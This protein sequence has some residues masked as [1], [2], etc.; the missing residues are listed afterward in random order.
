MKK[1]N[2]LL[3]SGKIPFKSTGTSMLPILY[4]DDIIYFKK[5]PF[6][7][8]K[9]NDIV[10]FKKNSQLITHRVIYKNKKHVITK[11]DNNPKSD[12]KIFP[13]QIIGKVYQIKRNDQIIKPETLYL[14]QS[15]H[16][17]EEI[18]KIK[19]EFDRQKINYVFLKGLPLH[20][21]FEGA[22][23]S[24]LYAD[25][26]VL[27]DKTDFAKA[28][29]ILFKYGYQKADTA[30]SFL[31]KK[32]K[33]K[34]S[35]NTY[36][37][38]INGFGVV[39]DI[40]LEVVFMMTQL[41]D[42]NP[43]YSQKLIDQMTKEFLQTRQKIKILGEQFWILNFDFLIVYL[44]LHLFHHNFTGAFR[45]QFLDTVVRKYQILKIKN[46]KYLSNIKNIINKYQINNFVY[47]AFYLL[48]KYYQTPLPPLFLKFIKPLH[49]Y[50]FTLLHLYTFTRLY[51]INIFNDEPRV[52]AGIK[53]FL[54][55]FFLSPNPL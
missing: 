43:L 13:K 55:L 21:Y 25:C 3:F 5:I 4:P 26:D 52:N 14:I 9:V 19:K 10:V 44:A 37:K 36:W 2:H 33:N 45:Y 23:P 39:F 46:Q 54:N 6:S 15:T 30:L 18:V 20:L 1:I 48:K 16:Y 42:L 7:K 38:N 51:K 32:L 11:G 22:H 53:R 35:E 17:F 28:E 8:I 47:P 29:K 41:G 34:E 49:F 12:G 50:T 27:I 24:R 40:H 31:Q